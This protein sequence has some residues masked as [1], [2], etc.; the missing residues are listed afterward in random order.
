MI[1][2]GVITEQSIGKLFLAG[3]IPGLLIAGLFILIIY[4]WCKIDPSVGPKSKEVYV[5][6]RKH[7]LFLN[8][9]LF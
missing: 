9:W 8:S 6:K 4:V 3:I 1:I 7:G 5:E 2:Y